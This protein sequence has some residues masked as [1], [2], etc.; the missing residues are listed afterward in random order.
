MRRALV[1][2]PLTLIAC[3]AE[4]SPPP[5]RAC[6]PNLVGTSSSARLRQLEKDCPSGVRVFKAGVGAGH[7]LLGQT[8]ADDVLRCE[9]ADANL[10]HGRD[11][12]LSIN[13]DYD[14]EGIY[15]PSRPEAR[16]RP[17]RIRFKRGVIERIE[18]SVYQVC[19]ETS[20]GIGVGSTE[21]E[22]VR[23]YGSDFDFAPGTVST[24]HYWKLGLAVDFHA[25][26]RRAMGF[27]LFI[28]GSERIAC[29]RDFP[30]ADRYQVRV[31]K[32]F[33][34]AI[35]GQSTPEEVIAALGSDGETRRTRSGEVYEIDYDHD[36]AGQYAPDRPA[37][38]E[39][40]SKAR[41]ER[42]RLTAL[43]FG[44]FQKCV[45]L[46]GLRTASTTAD[47]ERVLGPG[48]VRPPTRPSDE[49]IESQAARLGIPD[50]IKARLKRPS[51]LE[52]H[53]FGDGL[54]VWTSTLSGTINS[55]EI[56]T[57]PAAEPAPPP[58]PRNRNTPRKR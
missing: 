46:S 55:F 19:I 16:L 48:L 18:T 5:P 49:A 11:G 28:P 53:E 21:A 23:A 31:G 1:L 6:A 3:K 27:D 37:S 10:V 39:R 20:E 32:G 14:G 15:A 44:A 2:L 54:T 25:D 43:S 29:P 45:E 56:H 38:H 40:P 12:P 35:L 41:F 50:E 57:P 17:M 36:P 24:L 52:T 33:R 7:L 26:G 58:P 34:G 22:V 4:R 9:G 13:Y 30:A 42:G 8:S 47:L 51:S